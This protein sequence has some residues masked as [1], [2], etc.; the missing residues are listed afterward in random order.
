MSKTKHTTQELNAAFR[1]I[2]DEVYEMLARKAMAG[3]LQA[4]KLLDEKQDKIKREKLRMELFG[5]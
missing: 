3:N 5:V 1:I 2:D 4:V